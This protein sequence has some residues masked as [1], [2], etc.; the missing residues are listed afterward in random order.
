MSLLTVDKDTCTKCGACAA[1]CPAGIIYFREGR[2]PRLLPGTDEIC[3]R[4]GH[5]VAVCPSASLDHARSP[6]AET[7]PVDKGLRITHEQMVQLV[8]AR[9]SVR[10]F[11]DREVPR[12]ELQKL[13]DVARYAPTG[14]NNQEVRWHSVA[15][16]EKMQ[17]LAGLGADWMRWMMTNNPGMEE[18]LAGP[19]KRQEAGF[20]EFLRGAPAVVMACVEKENVMAGGDCAIALAYFDLLANTAGLGCCWGGFFNSAAAAFPPMM[21]A[22]DV[23]EGLEPRGSLMVGYPLYTYPRIPFRRPAEISWRP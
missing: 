3:I 23:P 1:V 13:I 10:E 2:F 16:R 20:D 18:M 4:C 9:R 12:E 6:L 21:K 19:L 8:R 17:E 5:C 11:Q 14:H 7:V 22:V 15:G